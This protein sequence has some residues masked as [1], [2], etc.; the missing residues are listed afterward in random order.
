M[1][2]RE[3]MSSIPIQCDG[4]GLRCRVLAATIPESCSRCGEPLRLDAERAASDAD[5]VLIKQASLRYPGVKR[6][7]KVDGVYV[8]RDNVRCLE[9]ARRTLARGRR[10]MVSDVRQ[11]RA[12]S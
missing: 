9:L 12:P 10:G 6:L 7:V 11:T 5:L 8:P 2:A 3:A 1:N 4:C